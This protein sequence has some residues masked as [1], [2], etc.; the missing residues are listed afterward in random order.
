[1]HG[2][3]S[4][5]VVFYMWNKRHLKSNRKNSIVCKT[6]DWDDKKKLSKNEE[7]KRKEERG[8]EK[9][10]IKDEMLSTDNPFTHKHTLGYWER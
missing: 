10:G 4:G 7:E 2:I 8:E 5:N 9:R 3:E 6:K 1:M